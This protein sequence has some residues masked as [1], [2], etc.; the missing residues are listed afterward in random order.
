MW[1]DRL[2]V[3]WIAGHEV[4]MGVWDHLRGAGPVVLHDVVVGGVVRDV[5]HRGGD[6]GTGEEGE[7]APDL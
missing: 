5:G 6:E 2:V 7:D 3:K 4:E 1:F